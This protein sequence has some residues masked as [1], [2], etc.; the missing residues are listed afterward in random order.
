MASIATSRSSRTPC[1][2]LEASAI[3]WSASSLRLTRP[4]LDRA[5]EGVQ[6]LPVEPL[7]GAHRPDDLLTSGVGLRRSLLEHHDVGDH[8]VALLVLRELLLDLH[9]SATDRDG[10]LLRLLGRELV[11]LLLELG[12]H[13]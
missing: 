12:L 2:R 4:L 3:A 11:A 8:R 5:E 6:R 7:F 10:L 13:L 1:P 9:G